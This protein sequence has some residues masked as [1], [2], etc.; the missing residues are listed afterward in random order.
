MNCGR[1]IDNERTARE[2]D[3]EQCVRFEVKAKLKERA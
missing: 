1:M 3:R 2:K